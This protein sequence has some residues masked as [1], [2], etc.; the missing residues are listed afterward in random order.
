MTSGQGRL[1]GKVCLVTG[2]TG[3]A[4]AG[5]ERFAAEGAAVFVAARREAGCRDL[6]ERIEQAGGRAAWA[7]ADLTDEAAAAAVAAACVERFGRIDGLYAVAGGS[8]RRFGDGPVHELT[9]DGWRRTMDLNAT[10]AFLAAREAVRAMLRQ[11][12]DE[13]GAR[14]AL[15][16]MTSVLATHPAPAH[17]ATHAYAASKGAIASLARAMA[18]HYAADGIRVN[19]IA[20]SLVDTPMAGRAIEDEGVAAYVRWKQ[21]LSG[22]FMAPGDIAAVA[23]FLLSDEARY[24]TGQTILVDA[25][26]SVANDGPP[27]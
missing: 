11:A 18:A 22:A 16:L 20:P 7:A 15:L 13:T 25:G 2:A 24:I 17:F 10:P 23:S 8:G 1:A 26:W 27:A 12:P 21:P 3:M 19:A 4:A 5:A 14:G 9:L 6:V